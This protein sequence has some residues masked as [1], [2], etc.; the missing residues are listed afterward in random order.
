MRRKAIMTP[1]GFDPMRVLS[2]LQ[3]SGAISEEDARLLAAEWRSG[4]HAAAATEAPSASR[5]DDAEYWSLR[6]LRDLSNAVA[7]TGRLDTQAR[8]IDPEDERLLAEH[9]RAILDAHRERLASTAR[10][11]D[12]GDS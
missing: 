10:I 6:F 4:Q 1:A 11:G 7:N 2:D 5:L 9:E 8:R 3:A 12:T